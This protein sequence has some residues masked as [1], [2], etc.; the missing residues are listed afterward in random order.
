VQKASG[1]Q[2]ALVPGS[3]VA[4]DSP[5]ALKWRESLTAQMACPDVAATQLTLEIEYTVT[6]RW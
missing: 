5:A 6:R 4:T 3:F 2:G 1:V